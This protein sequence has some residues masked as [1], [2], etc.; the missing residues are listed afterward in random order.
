MNVNLEENDLEC[1]KSFFFLVKIFDMN[2]SRI[3]KGVHNQTC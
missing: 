3:I 2:Y 1:G